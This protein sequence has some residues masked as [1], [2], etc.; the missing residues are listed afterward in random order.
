MANQTTVEPTRERESGTEQDSGV[1]SAEVM[2]HA[3][4]MTNDVLYHM[5]KAA[6]CAKRPS[7]WAISKRTSSAGSGRKNAAATATIRTGSSHARCA[8]ALSR[9]RFAIVALR[10]SSARAVLS[11]IE[12]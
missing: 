6:G 11:T 12:G 2:R 5:P 10:W 4:D 1:E 9:S 8:R 3:Q 7:S